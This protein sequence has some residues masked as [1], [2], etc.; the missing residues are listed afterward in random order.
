MTFAPS[1]A[2]GPGDVIGSYRIRAVLEDPQ[3]DYQ[4]LLAEHVLIGR[5]V[6]L[7][8]ATDDDPQAMWA[9]R[10]ERAARIMSRLDHPNV[11]RVYEVE[12]R[13][14][15]LLV[16]TEY[17]EGEGIPDAIKALADGK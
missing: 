9:T 1:S 17:V 5:T 10:L 3:D 6:A 13:D 2:L 14:G 7:K 11:V 15:R 8:V 16:A 4:Q 12:I